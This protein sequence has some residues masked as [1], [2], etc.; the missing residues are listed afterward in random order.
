MP[1]AAKTDAVNLVLALGSLNTLYHQRKIGSLTITI[2]KTTIELTREI[3]TTLRKSISIPCEGQLFCTINT[4]WIQI[5][6]FARNIKPG[7]VTIEIESHTNLIKLN[8]YTIFGHIIFDD[9]KSNQLSL[10][11]GNNELQDYI[12]NL[13][14]INEQTSPDRIL[15]LAQD[16]E[17]DSKLISLI[18]KYR[19]A[20][21]QICGFNFIQKN[22]SFYSEAHHLEQLSNGGLDISKNILIL[23]A[24]H[25][26]QFHYGNVVVL[27]HTS[28]YITVR[29]DE[30][31]FTCNISDYT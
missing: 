7:L 25:H 10:F 26:R 8:E 6:E 27:E 23:C 13:D 22:G 15:K 29:I 16:F 5:H 19:G 9:M 11:S 4:Y 30:E 12:K 21:C 24:N 31:V 28:N 18:K 20:S 2:R 17:R 3:D 14:K 1:L